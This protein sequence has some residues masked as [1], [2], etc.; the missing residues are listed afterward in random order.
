[1]IINKKHTIVHEDY[2]WLAKND[3]EM[4]ASMDID[5]DGILVLEDWKEYYLELIS[6]NNIEGLEIKADRFKQPEFNLDFLKKLKNLKYLRIGG[7]FKKK[8]YKSIEYLNNLEQLSLADYE[9][10]EI[11][12]TNFL[13]LKSYFS[14]IKHEDHPIFQHS[15]IEHLSTNTTL[16]DF[17]CFTNLTQL[18][19]LDLFARNLKSLKNIEA[20]QRLESIE[21]VYG[22]RLQIHS[23]KH[24]LEHIKI[25]SL[26]G[27]KRIENIDFIE[28][29]INLEKL[30]LDNCGD[31]ES[32]KPISRLSSMKY[33]AFCGNTK[34]LDGNLDFLKP[35]AQKGVEIHFTPSRHY[36]VKAD[37]LL[38]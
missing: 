28:A 12:F 24:P 15:N 3:N 8:E 7:K 38:D 25:F 16:E 22:H 20:M 33:I 23:F 34:I 11:D 18:K 35:L 30:I 17:N 37:E 29:L 1:M 13:N 9:G 2:I 31:I 36:S 32:L 6:A 26:N 21:I 14:P 19:R 10:Y 5:I 4:P 27:C